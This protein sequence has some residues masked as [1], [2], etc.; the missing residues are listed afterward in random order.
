MSDDLISR[1]AA[2]DD[3]H[4]QIWYRLNPN[5]KERIDTWL[6]NLPSV[7]QEQNLAYWIGA[8]LGKCSSCGHSGCASDIWNGCLQTFCPNCGAKME[9]YENE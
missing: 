1:K 9:D 8:E 4:R 6:V 7:Q 5:M 3:A 2:I